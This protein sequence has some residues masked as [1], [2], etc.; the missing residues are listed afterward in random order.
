MR[1]ESL[2]LTPVT[3]GNVEQSASGI[4]TG[5]KNFSEFLTEAL[6]EVN[7]LQNNSAKASFDLA[8][9]KLQDV[10]QVTI[11]TEKASIAIQLTMQVR[12]KMI[13]AYQEI[14]RMQV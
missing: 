2:K 3:S 8:A 9:G 12:N 1:V 5:N 10:S 7:Q 13:D 6:G 11:A 4:Q 14:M